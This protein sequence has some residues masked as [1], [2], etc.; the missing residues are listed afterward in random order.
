MRTSRFDIRLTPQEKAGLKA[1]A[2]LSG[3]SLSSWV[4]MTLRLHAR[5]VLDDAGLPVPFL[6]P[7][8]K[9]DA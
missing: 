4:R 6:K 8:G 2:D 3:L 5:D 1:V 7:E 9:S